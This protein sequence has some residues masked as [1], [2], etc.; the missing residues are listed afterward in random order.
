MKHSF[1][2]EYGTLK[3]MPIIREDIDSLR[4][5]RN[6]KSINSFLRDIGYITVERQE[7]WFQEYLINDEEIAFGIHDSQIDNNN[8]I[9][10]ISLYNIDMNAHKAM[11]GHFLI[12]SELA[13]SRSI[14][15]NSIV[16][17]VKAGHDLLGL[18]T[19]DATVH[20]DN[21]PS[22]KCFRKTGFRRI[23]VIESTIG[24]EDLLETNDSIVRERIVFFESILTYKKDKE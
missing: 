13:H 23:D 18:N 20:P 4:K 10:S 12:G 22:Q 6:D 5:W 24:K 17:V 15:K 19:F 7:K 8:I 9:G 14:G 2:A 21:L 1:F 16:M 3:L 11:V